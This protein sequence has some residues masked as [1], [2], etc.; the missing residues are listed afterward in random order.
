MTDKQNRWFVLAV[1]AGCYLPVAADATILNIAVPSLTDTLGATAREVLWIADIYPLMM[2]GLV[3]VTG[4]LGDRMGH[5]RLLLLGLAV[6][7]VASAVSAFSPTPPLLIAGRAALA[8]GA[9]MIIPATLAIIRQVFHDDRER[10]VAIG[11]WSA[12]ASGGAAVGPV[13]GGA[14]LEHF[15]WGSVFLINVPIVGLALVLVTVLLANRAAEHKEPWEPLSPVLGIVGVVGVVYAVKAL[16]HSG[17]SA[18]EFLVPG[19]V[20]AT[21]LVLF[22]RRQLRARHPMLDL[23]L[24]AERRFRIGVLASVV[25]VLVMVGFELLLAQE[26]QFVLG[27]S[28]WEAG[29]FLLP[30]PIAAFVGGP[31]GG[32]LVS[33]LGLRGV[34]SAG[35]VMAAVGYAGT[36]AFSTQHASGVIMVCLVLIG[37]GHGAVQ[38]V[39]SDAIM[40]GAPQH[41]A[42]AAAS[43]ESVSYEVGA[44]LGIALL[45]SLMAAL[46]TH[47]FVLPDKLEAVTPSEA[48]NSIGEGVTAARRVGGE[49]GDLIADAA[50]S[51][52][53]YG[54][55]L[56]AVVA[57]VTVALLAM[58]TSVA[59]RQRKPGRQE[60][61]P[62]GT[63]S[64]GQA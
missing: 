36:A 57:C 59:L 53:T 45:G 13:A 6:F 7:G 38:T 24:F 60:T 26:L 29:F 2:V 28:P 30:M 56:T 52:Y 46:Y 63:A 11:V 14:L 49:A 41:R 4:P 16:A 34:V 37:A 21:V 44:G 5:K 12:V 39:A 22:V 8:T 62:A 9:S 18:T 35:L 54:F 31:L 42:G 33:R 40:T 51:A 19:L 32:F 17:S 25:P 23:T 55:R 61:E 15:W 64:R 58:F 48:G 27:L 3:L 50:R 1:V 47:S 43:I 10:A 20:G